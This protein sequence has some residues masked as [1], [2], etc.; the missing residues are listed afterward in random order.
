MEPL[1]KPE[2][3]GNRPEVGNLC[4]RVLV[5]DLWHAE[6][7]E[8]ATV[9]PFAG[10][11]AEMMRPFEQLFIADREKRAA[12]RRKHG[13]LI[14]GPLD[15][16]QRRPERLDFLALVKGAAAN[17]HVW[18]STRLERFD[19]GTRDIRLPAHE[20]PEE[21]TDVLCR[22]PDGSIAAALGHHPLAVLH[23]PVDEGADSIW[24]RLLDGAAG[25]VTAGIRLR[26]RQRDDRRLLV[27]RLPI[28]RERHVVRL[29][30]HVVA[31]HHRLERRIHQCL[32][33]RHAAEAPREVKEGR[34]PL[35]HPPA[36]LAVDR[37]IGAP[38][39]VDRLL[40]IA[41]EKEPAGERPGVSPILLARIVG[42]KQQQNL[43]LQRVGILELVDEDPLEAF[44]EAR[45]YLTVAAHEIP[46]EEQQIE[47]V[48]RAVLGFHLLVSIECAAQLL[49]KESRKVGIRV[50]AE[51]IEAG[52]EVGERGDHL[53]A[54]DAVL[55]PRAAALLD[56]GERSIARQVDDAGFPAVVVNR[57]QFV[58][59]L[60]QGNLVAQAANR[61]GAHP[62]GIVLRDWMSRQLGDIVLQHHQ[63]VDRA[64]AI[65][66]VARPRRREIPPLRELPGC[67]AQ[68]IDWTIL[69]A[70]RRAAQRATDAIRRIGQDV[71]QPSAEGFVEEPRR[72]R[73]GQY[74][75]ERIDTGLDWTFA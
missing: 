12:Q 49:L 70:E 33:L 5:E 47:K 11:A 68:A 21:E 52:P 30:R 45:T 31:G 72:C 56:V 37:N 7:V 69:A 46:C 23:D 71:L 63:R 13:Q 9:E 22:H 40:R 58:K 51:L 55:V 17:E 27:E 25:H 48:E 29:Q 18:N 4:R 19:V 32:N 73:F 16:R 60:L 62:Q 36:H 24:N 53:V 15:G 59:G 26:Y 14:V 61:L 10:P 1:Q 74:V 65:E 28:G 8:D 42:G 35:L 54:F 38:K 44:L 20:S 66:R 41:D 50:H 6:W 39:A 2:R 57:S 67:L 64:F 75:E 3:F 43:R 34:A